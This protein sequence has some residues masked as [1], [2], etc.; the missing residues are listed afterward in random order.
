MSKEEPQSNISRSITPP[1]QKGRWHVFWPYY[2]PL[3]G[4]WLTK[5]AYISREICGTNVR[6]PLQYSLVN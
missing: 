3:A 2:T 4:S 1:V 6:F 5:M